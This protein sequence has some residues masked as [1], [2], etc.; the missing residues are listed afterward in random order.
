MSWSQLVPSE[1]TVSTVHK[2]AVAPSMLA[3]DFSRIADEVKAVEKTGAE[4]LHLDVMD[5][6][7]VPALTFGPILV[8]AIRRLTDMPLDSHLMVRNPERQIE[9]FVE[10]GS[11]IVVIHA[12]ASSDISRDLRDI[13]D[14]GVKSGLAINPDNTTQNIEAYL[15]DVDMLLVMSVFPGKGGQAFMESSLANVERAAEIRERR[16][17]GFAIQIDGGINPDTAVRARDAGAEILVAGTAIFRTPDYQAAVDA[18][19]GG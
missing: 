10:A 16:G 1:R 19:R 2:T 12:E 14:R 7:F 3:A 18:I 17:L 6:Q 8:A 15:D 5:G 9:P 11:D 13:R 4:F